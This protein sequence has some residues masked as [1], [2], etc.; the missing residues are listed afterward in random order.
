MA[1]SWKNPVHNLGPYIVWILCAEEVLVSLAYLFSG[2][3]RMAIYW[4]AGATI[5]AAVPK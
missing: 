2:N 4:A 5:C 3:Y 1:S